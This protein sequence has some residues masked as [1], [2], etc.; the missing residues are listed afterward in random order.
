M[1]IVHHVRLDSIL[2]EKRINVKH[3]LRDL[4]QMH[5]QQ[6]VQNV[7]QDQF[8]HK[9]DLDRVHH[10]LVENGQQKDLHNV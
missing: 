8:Q 7:Q 1:E 2:K 4:I 5:K 10:V 9:M 3:V 6:V